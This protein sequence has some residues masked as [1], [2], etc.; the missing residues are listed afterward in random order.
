MAVNIITSPNEPIT[1]LLTQVNQI[2]L[3]LSEFSKFDKNVINF[4]GVPENTNDQVLES[5]NNYKSSKIHNI[6][7]SYISFCLIIIFI[8]FFFFKRN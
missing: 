7:I 1:S 5:Y 2:K 3:Q 8:Y 4:K 6:F